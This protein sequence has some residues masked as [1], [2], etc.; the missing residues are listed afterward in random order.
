MLERAPNRVLIEAE[1]ECRGLR[2]R[3]TPISGWRARVDRQ[4]PIHAVYGALRGEPNA[5]ATPRN[6]PAGIGD[7]RGRIQGLIR[8]RGVAGAGIPSAVAR[9]P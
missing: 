7:G 2:W 5:D 8:D 9:F 1:M 3:R 6:L 4:T